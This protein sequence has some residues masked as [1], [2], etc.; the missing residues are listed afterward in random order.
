M[1]RNAAGSSSKSTRG[2]C[3]SARAIDTRRCSPPL[4][5]STGRA[6]RAARS[7]R[8]DAPRR[9]RRG[10]RSS[11]ASRSPGAAPCPSR[12]R[13][14]PWNATGTTSLCGTKATRRASVCRLSRRASRPPIRT[15][16]VVAGR[17]PAATRK[18][19]DLPAPFA[20]SKA[21]TSPPRTRR[22]TSD[23]AGVGASGY[24]T[25]TP[26]SSRSAAAGAL[27]GSRRGASCARSPR[28]TPRNN[29]LLDWYPRSRS[30]S[31]ERSWTQSPRHPRRRLR[32]RQNVRF[33]SSSDT[34]TG[35]S[36]TRRTAA[37]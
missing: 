15:V 21:A 31:G 11:R 19:V 2:R 36:T 22:V 1:S 30:A 25:D 3:A 10:P 14:G 8:A 28:V 27:A 26:S 13:H 20:P 23:S 33:G 12:P 32:R 4:S 18:S 37:T 6:A 29:V 35:S 5:V 7:Q 9:S 34:R 16:P 24:R 17:R